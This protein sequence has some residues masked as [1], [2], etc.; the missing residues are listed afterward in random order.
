VDTRARRPFQVQPRPRPAQSVSRSAGRWIHAGE[1]LPL[2]LEPDQHA[3]ERHT[4]DEGHGAIDGIE[5]PARRIGAG[6]LAVLFAEDAVARE[7][8]LDALAEELLRAAIGRRHRGVVGLQLEGGVRLE[9]TQREG[10]GELRR[11][12]GELEDLSELLRVHGRICRRRREVTRLRQRSVRIAP[13]GG[14]HPPG[15]H[16]PWL[17]RCRGRGPR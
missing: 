5:D 17:R 13:P 9:M 14:A 6:H 8:A 12:H 2:P 16:G 4:A 3:V 7:R 10:P 15:R 11:L 1:H